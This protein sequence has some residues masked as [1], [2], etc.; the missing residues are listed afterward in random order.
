MSM[1]AVERWV[2]RWWKESLCSSAVV[3]EQQSTHLILLLIVGVGVWITQVR[4]YLFYDV[5]I[6]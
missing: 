4:G 6:F 3:N 1:V 5:L 2:G